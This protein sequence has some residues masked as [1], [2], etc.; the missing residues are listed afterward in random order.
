MR[1]VTKA[2]I[3]STSSAGTTVLQLRVVNAIVELTGTRGYPPTL[4]EVARLLDCQ[5][6]DVYQKLLR[7][8][9]DGVVEWEDGKCR[10]LRVIG[11]QH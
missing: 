11:V 2:N 7:L 5:K 10:T 4:S 9:R 1:C 6:T 3:A 8:R